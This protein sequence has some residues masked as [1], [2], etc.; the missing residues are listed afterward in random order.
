MQSLS[1]IFFIGRREQGLAAVEFAILLPVVLLI[2]LATAELGRALYQY[3][4]LTKAV[5]DGARYLS[6]VAITGD[7]GIIDLTTAKI[8]ETKNLVVFGNVSGAG[9]TLLPGLTAA[10]ITI[11]DPPPDPLHVRVQAAYSY[12]PILATLPGFGAMADIS[13]AW[14]LT[15][16]ATMR[17]L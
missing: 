1:R 5:R 8:T 16:A 9:T 2:M 10:Q 3:N 15:A 17:A 12:Q 7:V 4:T 11:L 13:A 6:S 14:T